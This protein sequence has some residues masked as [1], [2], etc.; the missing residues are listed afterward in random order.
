MKYKDVIISKGPRKIEGVVRV[1]GSKNASLPLLT[2]TLLCEGSVDLINI[3]NLT[4]IGILINI[5]QKLGTKI[6]WSEHSLKLTH[7]QNEEKKIIPEKLA[8]KIRGSIL[9][10]AP[11]LARYKE[12]ILPMPGGC[13]IGQRPIDF[14]LYALEQLGAHFEIHED[15]VKGVAPN[16]LTGGIIKFPKPTVTGTENALMA[17]VVAKGDTEIFNPAFDSEIDELIR[18][19]ILC[20]AKIHKTKDTIQIQGKGSLLQAPKELFSVFAD[21]MEAGS[22]LAACAIT[23]G[24]ISL[25]YDKCPGLEPVIDHLKKMGMK[26]EIMLDGLK[27]EVVQPLTAV[28]FITAPHP[29][30]PTD[31]Q[32]PFMALNCVAQGPSFIEEKIWEKR[33]FH[34][35]G[36]KKMGANLVIHENRVDIIGGNKLYGA[37]VEAHDLRGSCALLILSMIAQGTTIMLSPQH[38]DRGYE[39]FINKLNMLGAEFNKKTMTEKELQDV[40]ISQIDLIA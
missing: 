27:A 13:P 21:R 15:S 23:G 30:F 8:N 25:K 37:L 14:H 19:L 7:E 3:P 16:G 11:M 5:L 4:D 20:G 36:F 29:G 31:L 1:S 39:F 40:Y 2:A 38:L 22:L 17:A 18:F 12:V 33:F 26:I 10:L 34:A 9:L 6:N 24:S 28:S 32:A 35:E